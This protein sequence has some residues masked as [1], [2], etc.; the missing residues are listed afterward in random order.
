M[1]VK[2]TYAYDFDKSLE[3]LDNYLETSGPYS[4]KDSIPARKD[5]S[6][7]NGYYVPCYAL[8][9]DIRDSSHLPQKH[10]KPV[11]AKIYRCYIS[12]LV[13]IMQSYANCKE[14][15]I[16][17]DCVSGV[18]AYN[19]QADV[20]QPFRAAYQINSLVHIL[21]Y[22]LS[23]KNY[24]NIKI[25]IGIAKGTALMVQA[26]YKGSAI[27]DVVWMGDVVNKASHLCN[28]AN[29]GGYDYA[30]LISGDVYNDL[31]GYNGGRNNDQPY[32]SMFTLLANDIYGGN[33]I[34]IYMDDWLQ[35]QK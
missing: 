25:G 12:E 35:K 14:I 31:K 24:E 19:T 1:E 29:K 10:R 7:T 26:G 6:Y 2:T 21:N 11:L 9:V 23:K 30:M 13:A 27:E 15:N 32:Q 22:K 34:S 16:V 17:G 3:R 33:I 28:H 18:F 4:E 5:L 20:L 8:F